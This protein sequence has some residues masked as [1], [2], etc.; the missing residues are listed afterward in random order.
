MFTHDP[1]SASVSKGFESPNL[2]GRVNSL[3][4]PI[5]TRVSPW[6]NADPFLPSSKLLTVGSGS[7]GCGGSVSISGRCRLV[8]GMAAS[9]KCALVALI[10]LE[11]TVVEGMV[12][13]EQDELPSSVGLDFRARLDGGRMAKSSNNAQDSSALRSRSLPPVDWSMTEVRGM[14]IDCT[15]GWSQIEE[16]TTVFPCEELDGVTIA[17][18][19][20]VWE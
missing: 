19:G 13:S 11:G 8:W 20:L 6:I 17:L 7:S 18:G 9:L 15:K 3:R 14:N 5:F 10:E 4:S 12:M 1:K 2:Q 16:V